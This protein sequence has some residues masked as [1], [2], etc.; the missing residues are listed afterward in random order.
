MGVS[1]STFDCSSYGLSTLF[2]LFSVLDCLLEYNVLSI[3]FS[4]Q[5]ASHEVILQIYVLELR[6]NDFTVFSKVIILV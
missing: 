6:I 2:D 1:Y 4:F 5:E 3:W